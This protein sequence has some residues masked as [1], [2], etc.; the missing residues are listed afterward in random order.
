MAM[1]TTIERER[2][3]TIYV[4]PSPESG[5]PPSAMPEPHPRLQPDRWRFHFPW[6]KTAVSAPI[7]NRELL[8]ANRTDRTWLVWHNYH[9]LGLLDAG[10]ERHVRVVR[11]GTMSARELLAD[12]DSE[13]LLVSLTS[14]V[15]GIEIV[16]IAAG[17]GL[18]TLRPMN[19]A[20]A[21][22]E[23]VPNSTAI[24]E[25]GLSAKT[26]SALKRLGVRTAG[27]LRETDL[28]S[29]WEVRSGPAAYAELVEML[30]LHASGDRD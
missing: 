17:E 6:V 26:V 22:I 12:A 29:L 27:Q 28:G 3:R 16:D 10:T 5:D 18:Y 30:F 14:E 9:N 20:A 21:S 25:L 19:A 15:Q 13:Y 1:S 4:D 24:E 11:A 23:A 7:Y 2:S 8:I